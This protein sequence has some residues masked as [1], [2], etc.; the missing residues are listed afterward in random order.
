MENNTSILDSKPSSS[1]SS[2]ISNSNITS[3]NNINGNNVNGTGIS[4]I[5]ESIKNI[6]L[7]TWILI[8]LILALLG[9]NIFIYLA[10]GTEDISTIFTK[11][12]GIVGLTTKKIVDVSLEG[13]KQIVNGT[14]NVYDK[15]ATSI[16]NTIDSTASSVVASS[17][18][19]TS[20]SNDNYSSSNTNKIEDAQS[21]SLNKALNSAQTENNNNDYEAD[22]ATSNIQTAGGSTSKAGWCYIGEDK[23]IRTCTQ[24]GLSDTCMS[25]DIFPS[26]EIC[27]NPKLRP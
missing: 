26:N 13:S 15:T 18:A 14:A 5:W 20:L 22:E 9:F 3:S 10:A 8:I 16:Q 17:T 25:G 11:I 6:P 19:Q 24:V 1:L 4:G 21:N 12:L 27:I 7:L 2:F 23:G